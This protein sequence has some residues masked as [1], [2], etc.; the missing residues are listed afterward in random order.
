[1]IRYGLSTK[2]FSSMIKIANK[3]NANWADYL[4]F[5]KNDGVKFQFYF[6]HY[7]ELGNLFCK[8]KG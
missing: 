6:F 7:D 5:M 3:Q 4:E 2:A 8:A 1:M